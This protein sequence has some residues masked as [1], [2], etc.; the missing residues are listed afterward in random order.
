MAGPP[1]PLAPWSTLTLAE[2]PACRADT[3]GFRGIV[4]TMS[5]WVRIRVGGVSPDPTGAMF[6]RVRWSKARV[7]L[8]AI[9]VQSSPQVGLR[10]TIDSWLVARFAGPLLAGL[11]GVTLG[12]E[13]RQPLQ[14]TLTPP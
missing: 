6:A 13:I 5:S 11:V 7:C 3:G 12:G 10:D 1:T 9:E 4:Q 2:D 8:E 14:C